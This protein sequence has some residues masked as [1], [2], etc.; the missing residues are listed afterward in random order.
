M[1]D[2]KKTKKHKEIL[3][4]KIFLRLIYEEWYAEINSSLLKS[5]GKILELGSGAGFMQERIPNVVASEVFFTKDVDIIADAQDLPFKDGVLNGIVMVDVLHHIQNVRRFFNEATR[6]ISTGGVI[7]MIEPWVNWWS[8]KI[9]K[10]LH[11]EPFDTKTKEWEIPKAKTYLSTAN[12]ALPWILFK[13]DREIFEREFP[14]WK[15]KLIEPM[16]PFRYLFSGGLSAPNIMPVS[17]FC[18]WKRIEYHFQAKMGM[19]AKIVLVKK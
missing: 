9:Y 19:F 13:R 6:C 2:Q 1:D 7:I 12:Q 3:I 17:T 4:K 15:I 11:H 5:D 10:Y 14:Q 16:M 18:F 8:S